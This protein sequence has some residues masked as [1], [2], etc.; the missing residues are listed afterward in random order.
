MINKHKVAPPPGGKPLRVGASPPRGARPGVPRALK[1]VPT[2][3]T[4]APS[5]VQ[6]KVQDKN[7]SPERNRTDKRDSKSSTTLPVIKGSLSRESSVDRITQP[8]LRA[9]KDGGPAPVRAPAGGK[10]TG[11]TPR[12]SRDLSAGHRQDSVGGGSGGKRTPGRNS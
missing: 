7:S 2:G 4:L 9:P 11:L 6:A 8:P 5:E 1:A 10:S 12:G 3:P